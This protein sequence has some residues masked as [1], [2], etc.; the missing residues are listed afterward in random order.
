[1]SHGMTRLCSAMIRAPMMPTVRGAAALT[2]A[3]RIMHHPITQM[4]PPAVIREVDIERPRDAN[5]RQLEQ[6]QPDTANEEEAGQIVVLP[7]I[8]KALVP[9]RK[10]KAGAT[11]CVTQRVK[12]IPAVGPR[13]GVRSRRGRGRSPSG[14]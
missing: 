10:M 12:K 6:H 8:E 2:Q 3:I 13:R 4:T 14:P 9:A 1:M 7:P 11:K 5:H